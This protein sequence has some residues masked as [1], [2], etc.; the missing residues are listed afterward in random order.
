[1]EDTKKKRFVV[2]AE[3]PTKGME[4]THNLSKMGDAVISATPKECY[5]RGFMQ[6]Y[7]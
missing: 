4:T 6:Y 5:P 7:E 2:F 1:M 3:N